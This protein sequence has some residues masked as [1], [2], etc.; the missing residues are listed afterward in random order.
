M[1]NLGKCRECVPDM[2]GT[3]L[4]QPGSAGDPANLVW[5]SRG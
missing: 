1:Y 5:T 2:V 4:A 3:H